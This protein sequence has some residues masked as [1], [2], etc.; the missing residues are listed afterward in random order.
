M[1]KKNKAA[2][3]PAAEA[4]NPEFNIAGVESNPEIQEALQNR[5]TEVAVSAPTAEDLEFDRMLEQ[6]SADTEPGDIE[7]DL[8]Q[9]LTVERV[10]HE[11]LKDHVEN[12]K[13]AGTINELMDQVHVAKELG[14]DSIDG[15]EKLIRHYCRG[16]NYPTKAGYFIFHDIKVHIPNQFE[17]AKKRD[18]MTIEQKVFGKSKVA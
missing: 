13:P 11:H 4:G 18:T 5:D 14:C 10:T 6:E 15:T 9:A 1:S 2:Q 16:S 17:A 3:G 12:Y 7:P 8:A